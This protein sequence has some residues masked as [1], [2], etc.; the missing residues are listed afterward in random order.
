MTTVVGVEHPQ[1]IQ[2]SIITDDDAAADDTA[3]KPPPNLLQS[4]LASIAL[5]WPM[6]SDDVGKKM[7]C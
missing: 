4:V 1:H 3:T 6:H 2:R 7:K 5:I